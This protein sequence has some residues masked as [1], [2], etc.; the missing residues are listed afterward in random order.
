MQRNMVINRSDAKKR[1]KEGEMLDNSLPESPKRTKVHAQRKFAQGSSLSSPTMTP[2]K[3]KDKSKTNGSVSA[4]E[5]IPSKRPKTED[6]LTFL[7]L[8]G[9]PI[10]PPRLDFFNLASV[11]DGQDEEQVQQVPETNK[12]S[13]RNK[14]VPL[15]NNSKLTS[16]SVPSP[17]SSPKL[18]V[19]VTEKKTDPCDVSSSGIGRK[20]E[21]TE[22]KESGIRNGNAV[23]KRSTTAVQALK[24][25]YQ[26][27]RLAKQ[28][29]NA[30]SKLV[31]IV[32]EKSMMRTR[33]STST[34][35]IHLTGRSQ[36][37]VKLEKLS[38][39]KLLKKA[40]DKSV[41]SPKKDQSAKKE[42]T[43]PRNSIQRVTRSIVVLK[44]VHT[45]ISD[46]SDA[47][48]SNVTD[49]ASSGQTKRSSLRSHGSHILLEEAPLSKRKNGNRLSSSEK[50]NTKP[51]KDIN[52]SIT[53]A[54]LAKKTK[55]KSPTKGSGKEFASS[56]SD[57]SSDDDQPLVKKASKMSIQNVRRTKLVK[58]ALKRIN[59]K[60][61]KPSR[62][63]TRS[64]QHRPVTS[65]HR[66][67]HRPTRKTKEAATVFMELIGK[68]WTSP[69]EDNPEDE[70]VALVNFPD[71]RK[72]NK[73]GKGD[74]E[75]KVKHTNETS[76]KEASLK[77]KS[78]SFVKADVSGKKISDTKEKGR[79]V[80][81]GDKDKKN[82]ND[83]ED[84]KKTLSAKQSKPVMIQKEKILR[85]KM[86]KKAGK[87]LCNKTAHSKCISA[88][89]I[90]N[91]VG[92]LKGKITTHQVQTRNRALRSDPSN[93]VMNKHIIEERE[94]V[95]VE[96]DNKITSTYRLTRQSLKGFEE[97]P[98]LP[99][100]PV[101]ENKVEP[102]TKSSES[103]GS[104][105]RASRT[106]R[107]SASKST[108]FHP[109][110]SSSQSDEKFSDSDEEP[111]GRK[112]IKNLRQSVGASKSTPE[113]KDGKV[114]QD[115]KAKE[116]GKRLEEKGKDV[117][118]KGDEKLKDNLK[119][120]DDKLK[121]SVKKGDEKLK[122]STKKA[123]EKSKEI[124]KKAEE[125][126]KE[127]M[128]KTEEKSKDTA[129]KV[130]EKLKDNIS[131]TEDKPKESVKKGDEKSKDNLK[132][133][134]DKSKDNIKKI[135][136]KPKE[137]NKKVADKFRKGDEK[138]KDSMKKV[139]DNVKE[140]HK[141]LEEKSKKLEEKLKE[142]DKKVDD[143]LRESTKKSD[144]KLKEV[145]RKTDN[146]S[147]DSAKKSD[148]KTKEV[149]RRSSVTSK[150]VEEEIEAAVSE[151][152]TRARSS[153][154][155]AALSDI[156]KS[157]KS[158][159]VD[160]SGE[161]IVKANNVEAL[162]ENDS[163]HN[164]LQ[165]RLS[166]SS[167][168][169]P[170]DEITKRVTR[171]D[172]PK[173]SELV[174]KTEEV[175]TAKKKLGIDSITE[176]LKKT[177]AS[178]RSKAKDST[179][180]D[181]ESISTKCEGKRPLDMTITDGNHANEIGLSDSK[182]LKM[183]L[184]NSKSNSP[185]TSKLREECSLSNFNE[186]EKFLSMGSKVDEA[187]K[188]MKKDAV[189]PL[190][191]DTEIPI[192][193]L[194][195]D[196]SLKKKSFTSSSL[197]KKE[198]LKQPFIKKTVSSELAARHREPLEVRCDK[199]REKSILLSIETQAHGGL[200]LKQAVLPCENGE[201]EFSKLKDCETL[202]QPSTSLGNLSRKFETPPSN[203]S[204]PLVLPNVSSSARCSCTC[205][206]W[207]SNSAN[208]SS[209]PLH[210]EITN[211][212]Q[213]SVNKDQKLKDVESPSKDSRKSV[214]DTVNAE[215]LHNTS[216]FGTDVDSFNDIECGDSEVRR[217]VSKTVEEIEKWLLV[218]DIMNSGKLS[219]ERDKPEE[220]D[221]QANRIEFDN[222]RAAM[223][224]SRN[225]GIAQP[226]E[227]K[228]K[229]LPHSRLVNKTLESVE[230]GIGIPLDTFYNKVSQKS[231]VSDF[232][233]FQSQR[234]K[235]ED[236]GVL[237]STSRQG[238]L[239]EIHPPKA[240]K[241]SVMKGKIDGSKT[242]DI[243]NTEE[244]VC[245]LELELKVESKEVTSHVSL[246]SKG[247]SETKKISPKEKNT[248]NVGSGKKSSNLK[249]VRQKAEGKTKVIKEDKSSVLLK[250]A[251]SSPLVKSPQMKHSQGQQIQT[252]SVASNTDVTN[253]VESSSL[254]KSDVPKSQ[255]SP[256]IL[257][258][259]PEKK[260]IFLKGGNNFTVRKPKERVVRRTPSVGA[261][262]PENESSVY[263]F[264]TE[265][266]E[267]PPP[268][269]PFRRKTKDGSTNTS[270]GKQHHRHSSSSSSESSSIICS[271]IGSPSRK[272]A[273]SEIVHSSKSVTPENSFCGGLDINLDSAKNLTCTTSIAIQVNLDESSTQ[274]PKSPPISVPIYIP[275]SSREIGLSTSSSSPLVLVPETR[276]T[277]C[278][279]QTDV[280][281]ANE[282][283]DSESIEAP[284]TQKQPHTS[285]G[286]LFYIPLRPTPMVNQTPGIGPS[287]ASLAAN[288]LI[289]G[290]A[291]KLGT[292]G[293]TGPN[294]RVIMHAELVT[295]PPQFGPTIQC[296][297]GS[298]SAASATFSA[299]LQDV[300]GTPF[301]A[302]TNRYLQFQLHYLHE[303]NC[304]LLVPL[305]SLILAPLRASIQHIH[306]TVVNLPA[307]PNHLCHP[308]ILPI[309]VVGT[310]AQPL[311][312][313]TQS[314]VSRP[315]IPPP[316]GTVQPTTRPRPLSLGEARSS[317]SCVSST[318]T[319]TVKVDSNKSPQTTVT[320]P[321]KIVKP[322]P[323]SKENL[324]G[325]DHASPGPSG[326]KATPGS[327]KRSQPKSK[328]R[329]SSGP[330]NDSESSLSSN[331]ASSSSVSLTNHPNP[332]SA[333]PGKGNPPR[334]VEAPTFHP[335]EKE[336]QDPLEFI[337][338]IRPVAEKFGLC[339][340]VPPPNFKPDCQ[341][342]DDMRFTAYNQYV[343]KMF[344]RWGPNVKEMMVIKKYLKTQSISLTHPPWIGGMEV[345]LPR[346]Y[347]TVQSFGGLK[348]VIEKKKWQRVADGMRIPKSAQDR[349]T[350]LDDIY[351]KYLLPYDTLSPD[352]RQKLFDDIEK[353]WG[354]RENQPLNL[355]GQGNDDDSEGDG[356]DEF[357]ECIVKGRSMAL[358]AFYRIARNTMATWFRQPEPSAG[359]V[360]TEYW[361][362]V[363]TRTN[364]VCVHSGSIDSSVWGYGFP[365]TKGSPLAKH[366]WNLK[367]FTNNSGSI[368]RSMGPVMGVTVP[369]LHVG[370]LFTTC[371]WYR[372][373]HGLPWVEYLH[374]GASKIWYGI[375]DSQSAAFRTAMTKLVPRYC[376]NKTIWLP[377]D[378][379]MVPPNLL[380][381]NGVSLCRTVQEP[382]QFILV[383][384]RAF[385]SS[386]CAGYLVSESVYFSQ[387]GWLST[388]EEVFKDIKESCE[389]SM[390]S[391]KRFLIR[392]ATDPKSHVDVLKQV[393]PMIF[394]IR[395]DELEKRKQLSL[396][397]LK[398]SER[399]PQQPVKRNR[400]G[401]RS[402]QDD[403][404]DYECEICRANLYVS[405]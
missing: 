343:H 239:S 25:K 55:S 277:E 286:H 40:S 317:S 379:A 380:V 369:T 83:K 231:K 29:G 311:L 81:R 325:S 223:L 209:C 294:Q 5:L 368:L 290:V 364:H 244:K 118:K 11:P 355:E 119:K 252:S 284:V 259:T 102:K 104:P 266:R 34:D 297:T 220:S 255:R 100:K 78:K 173:V 70:L 123:S 377:S 155:S 258:S 128:S 339:R 335:T 234:V 82:S 77:E 6:F 238:Q 38:K 206:S 9:T 58:K 338:R 12:D 271:E 91:K 170:N 387:P 261:F 108:S 351:C 340:V 75:N 329:G 106:P 319:E 13:M 92:V 107:K 65:L 26:E 109:R 399:L 398:S 146:K 69:E 348:E 57:F 371:C 93:E 148:D 353:E 293:P 212:D 188:S 289:R 31:Q 76:K 336:F 85:E 301:V 16:V 49:R 405:L 122:E 186:K 202:S 384:P 132:K 201:I 233:S 287:S 257:T 97:P 182:K 322:P 71:V 181:S 140:I 285:E 138:L 115:E 291:V 46:N 121:E 153:K 321:P 43:S 265:D 264:E 304:F 185:A 105:G 315:S 267:A 168:N 110:S 241:T 403:D 154:I 41:V 360:E 352:E 8:R 227:V 316:V 327:G 169:S 20:S 246:T 400:K 10:L 131:K 79:E 383:F 142:L 124:N 218:S 274:T 283:I 320:E 330:S 326:S 192:E 101:S 303:L 342:S 402:T 178:N 183:S 84:I 341:V 262:S 159:A 361:R 378:T 116:T 404:G 224:E 381:K 235:E 331:K 4:S 156:S 248:G 269:T 376:R 162:K 365:C 95:V 39:S 73:Q 172:K 229:K 175:K 237:P 217:K 270:P 332:M 386:I 112:V 295:E 174:T 165:K 120:T 68:K 166:P 310:T 268:C 66:I 390:F 395:E 328:G 276:S 134:C 344:H 243:S 214:D 366:P 36:P 391:L 133:G 363:T 211:A 358:N 385:T 114:E 288:Q 312:T 208:V 51:T 63:M 61:R 272:S 394:R 193:L 357:D 275:S 89:V 199:M 382:G 150:T 281:E 157:L 99:P 94:V 179:K 127:N 54:P 354:D 397:G 130:D 298:L 230:K 305:M 232:M 370:M 250:S 219:E 28:R 60:N 388:A 263:A 164:L 194:K 90:R 167:P 62:M 86:R 292:E 33:S 42:E 345:D 50:Q 260:P 52:K 191:S 180:E 207:V 346:L 324:A 318:Q 236:I 53:D 87:V 350:K 245:K 367:I 253:L 80:P 205:K 278:S 306:S 242:L 23:N 226:D 374:T 147:K 184:E 254:L 300:K 96:S 323:K 309:S 139:D 373:P 3:D 213:V 195:M 307:D 204:T 393:L 240:G 216:A 362:H 135:D 24:K 333:F 222:L 48:G 299:D 98:A 30:I 247:K 308:S 44:E 129:K 280:G 197:S 59:M 334:M 111:L 64:Q 117:T 251:K 32:K 215:S 359:E 375:P 17:K 144:E 7:C 35:S 189:C 152:S 171:N 273:S 313:Q 45:K 19:K 14:T 337:E 145:S 161:K 163:P 22:S 256:N 126:S 88:K 113:K 56:L 296:Q 210:G 198:Q 228:D 279:T 74:S 47:N 203:S 225:P 18:P 372:D 401:P 151:R 158:P 196:P 72:M 249:S 221:L 396:L 149:S 356:P 200:I 347:Q 389:P 2:V 177:A 392:I 15:H 137:A 190:I 187:L 349:V 282:K 103:S 37:I 141:K 314:I 136:D 160:N 125:K 176:N 21:K 302:A 67:P 1:K 143:K 27:Q